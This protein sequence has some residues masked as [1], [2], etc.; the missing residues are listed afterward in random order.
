MDAP[1]ALLHFGASVAVLGWVCGELWS[2]D[3]ENFRNF[4]F[5]QNFEIDFLDPL[6]PPSVEYGQPG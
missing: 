5:F 2:F 6:T 1:G 3:R 4:R